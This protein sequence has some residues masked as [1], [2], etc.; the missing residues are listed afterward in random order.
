M[1]DGFAQELATKIAIDKLLMDG[2]PKAAREWHLIP[3]AFAVC[4]QPKAGERI[5][6]PLAVVSWSRL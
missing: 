6:C 2:F 3:L 4:I 1:S 5:R